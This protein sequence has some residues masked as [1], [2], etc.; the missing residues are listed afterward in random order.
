MTEK[1]LSKLAD[2]PLAQPGF[3]ALNMSAPFIVQ[4]N[5]E[6]KWESKTPENLDEERLKA[7]VQHLVNSKAI[8]AAQSYCCQCAAENQLP[9]MRPQ[10]VPVV[11]MPIFPSNQCPFDMESEV[12][13]MSDADKP[14]TKPTKKAKAIES[15]DGKEKDRAAKPKKRGFVMQRLTDFDLLSQW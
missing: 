5:N 3:D 10:Y 9:K 12:K 1:Q 4:M 11:M 6:G 14:K 13:K 8:S 15:K 7:I 2:I